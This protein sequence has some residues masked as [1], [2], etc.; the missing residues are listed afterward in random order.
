MEDRLIVTASPHIRDTSTTRGLMGNVVIALLPAVLAAGLIFG[1][2]ALVLVAVTTLA[3]VAFEYI[4]EKLLKKHFLHIV[5]LSAKT[6]DGL[7][8]LLNLIP[9]TVGLGDGA[10]DGALITNARQAAALARAAERC[11]AAL[12]AAQSGMTPDAVVMDAEGAITALGEI[13]GETVT[14]AVVT[15]IFSD[16][17]VGK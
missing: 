6:G 14:D 8:K 1:V 17:C 12:Y 4:Y 16:F 5:P 13:T 11:E 3:C 2:Q 9:R 7:D 15:R 10:F